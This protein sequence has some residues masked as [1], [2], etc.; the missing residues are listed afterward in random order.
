VVPVIEGYICE[1]RNIAG[2]RLARAAVSQRPDRWRMSVDWADDPPAT[3]QQGARGAERDN[4]VHVASLSVA[5]GASGMLRVRSVPLL[6]VAE[7]D[8]ALGASV[9]HRPSGV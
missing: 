4:Q 6:T 1:W 9:N 3:R 2:W 5:V 8:Q 7:M